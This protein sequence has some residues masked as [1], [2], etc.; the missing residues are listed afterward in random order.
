MANEK[1]GVGG[2]K[3][4]LEIKIEEE[5]KCI[6]EGACEIGVCYFLFVLES[7]AL[8]IWRRGKM[9]SFHQKGAVGR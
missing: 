8:E 6:G 3:R 7:A 1:T 5:A 4:P 9:E 2:D